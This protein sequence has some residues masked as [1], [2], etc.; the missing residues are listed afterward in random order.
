MDKKIYIKNISNHT[1]IVVNPMIRLRVQLRPTQRFPI[2]EEDFEI[3]ASDDGFIKMVRNKKLKVEDV[4]AGIETGLI[5]ME[6]VKTL[7]NGT[8]VQEHTE[9]YLEIRKILEK[10][11]DFDCKELIK[12]SSKERCEMIAQIAMDS[13]NISYNKIRMIS[14]ASGIDIQKAL[15]FKE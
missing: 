4:D 2:K 7:E 5:D 11:T 14:D 3:L 10:G 13:P 1:I 6:E 9:D 15:S 8:K 12:S